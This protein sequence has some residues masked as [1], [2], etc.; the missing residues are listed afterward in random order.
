MDNVP[1]KLSIQP[2][3]LTDIVQNFPPNLLEIT[4]DVNNQRAQVRNYIDDNSSELRS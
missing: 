1:N 4:L 2:K 3:V